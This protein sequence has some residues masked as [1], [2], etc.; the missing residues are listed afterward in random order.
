[1]ANYEIRLR[2]VKGTYTVE[3]EGDTLTG[4]GDWFKIEKGQETV[5]VAPRESLIYAKVEPSE[6]GR[7]LMAHALGER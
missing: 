5:F 6:H 7:G 1:M 4:S 2:G 3:V